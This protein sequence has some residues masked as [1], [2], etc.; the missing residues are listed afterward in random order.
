VGS[1]AGAG[2][3]ISPPVPSSPKQ[4][5]VPTTMSRHFKAVLVLSGVRVH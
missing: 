2:A 4:V 3:E 1:G 5:A